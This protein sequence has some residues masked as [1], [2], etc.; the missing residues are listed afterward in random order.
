M[1]LIC[2][3]CTERGKANVGGLLWRVVRSVGWER[4][5]ADGWKPEVLS[6]EAMFAGGPT[7]S[8]AEA[9]VKGVERR[10]LLIFGWFTRATG[11][12]DLGEEASGHVRFDG[13]VV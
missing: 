2:G 3:I 8:C 7:R 9:P 6:T 11:G 5:R 4:E 13:E 12:A 1:S 10:G